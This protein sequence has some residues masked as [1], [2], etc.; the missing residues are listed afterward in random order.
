MNIYDKIL[1][2]RC[3]CENVLSDCKKVASVSGVTKVFLCSH[4]NCDFPLVREE[5]DGKLI[6]LEKNAT[7]LPFRSSGSFRSS[8]CRAD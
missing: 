7:I 3:K 1:C 8:L 4:C 2:K 6:L 5:W